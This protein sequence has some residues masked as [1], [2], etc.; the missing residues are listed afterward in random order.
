MYRHRVTDGAAQSVGC[1]N[2]EFNVV[3]T[4]NIVNAISLPGKREIGDS[5]HA[6]QKKLSC[7]LEGPKSTRTRGP[8][9]ILQLDLN[10][11]EA[12]QDL[13]AQTVKELKVDGVIIADQYR[14]LSGPAW[15]T[16]ST[17]NLYKIEAKDQ[18]SV[19]V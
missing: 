6:G 14:N 4:D 17:N 8:L 3:G 15:V 19:S 13:L 9:K 11:C 10:H 7:V 2:L 18:R 5:T 16:D 1:E 12:A